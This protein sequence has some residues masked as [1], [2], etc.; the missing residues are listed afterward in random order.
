MTT[1]E[2]LLAEAADKGYVVRE[3]PLRMHDGR[4]KGNRIAIRK[5]IETNLRKA[6]TL[7]EELEHGESSC[8]DILDQSKPL[9]R[10]QEHRA[11]W[12][13]YRR[14]VALP[15]L[16]RAYEAGCRN[17]YEVSEEL[18]ISEEFLLK[19][20][21]RYADQY[22]LRPAN[23]DGYL[24]YFCPTLHIMKILKTQQEAPEPEAEYVAVRRWSD[25]DIRQKIEKSR[26]EHLKIERKLA[27]LE[28]KNKERDKFLLSIGVDPFQYSFDR[29]E[30][31][32]EME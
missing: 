22:G 31:A 28:K 11:R 21:K 27:R 32:R 30:R 2:K 23:C 29:A 16:V 17:L 8:G 12:R 7:A 3:K 10:K 25:E 26:K 6:E 14:M 24:I 15:E 1:Y 13:A 5:D 9:N 4:I 20:I 18:D 19:A